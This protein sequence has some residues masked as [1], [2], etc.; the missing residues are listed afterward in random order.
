VH[1]QQLVWQIMANVHQSFA[2]FGCQQHILSSF[3]G[4]AQFLQDAI[5]LLA[6]RIQSGLIPNHK[7]RPI[8]LLFNRDLRPN[9]FGNLR[10]VPTARQKAI[11]L[12]GR[13]TGE[14]DNHVKFV[15]GGGFKEQRNLDRAANPLQVAPTLRLGLPR[16]PD[17]RMQDRLQRLARLIVAKNA[18][19]HFIA[20]QAAVLGNHVHSEAITDRGERLRAGRAKLARNNIGIHDRQTTAFEPSAGG[21]FP[22]ADSAC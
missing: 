15:F 13:G 1:A 16:A 17:S 4:N 9:S 3:Q 8:D 12:D 6:Q 18:S 21:G 7:V 5:K 20:P 22:H 11:L 19:G 14:T 2:L 10:L